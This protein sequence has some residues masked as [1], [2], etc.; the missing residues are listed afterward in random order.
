MPDGTPLDPTLLAR[1][2]AIV[3]TAHAVTDPAEQA[4]YLREWRDYYVGCTPL[5]VKPGSTDEVSRILALA[6]ATRT[7]VVTQSGNTGLTGGQIPHE[8]GSEILLNLTRLDRI[9]SVDPSGNTLVA[10]AGVPLQRVQ[11]AADAVDRLFPLSLASQGSCRIGGNLATNAGGVGVLAYGNARDLAL[12]LEV[13][14]ADGRIWN[15]LKALRKDNTGYDLRNLFVGSEGTLGVITAAVLKLF[16]KPVEQA[17]AFAGFSSLEAARGLFMRMRSGT[18]PG[19]TAFELIPR[20]G[21]EFVV[22][23]MPGR[24]DPLASA[25]PWYALIELSGYAPDGRTAEHLGEMLAA[26]IDAGEIDDAAVASSLSQAKAFWN[27]RELLSE[28]Q[29]FEGGSIKHDVSVP[30][31]RIPEMVSRGNAEI[32]RVMPGARPL[33]FGHFGDGNL[34]YNVSQPIGMDKAAF[35]ASTDVISDPIYALVTQLGGSISAEHGIGRAKRALLASVKSPVEL[36]LMR[37]IKTALDPLGI[38]NPGKLL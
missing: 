10:E 33:P 6:H 12:G 1:F 8:D 4:P 22:R 32:A 28:T 29:K 21:I 9:R 11:E 2:A 5:I 34:H 31:D 13:V 26:A 7:P 18:G 23:H 27:L 30:V 3:G 35:L 19:L 20:L 16:P 17:T 24:R 15:G 14:L 38:L 25:H 36:D 37:A